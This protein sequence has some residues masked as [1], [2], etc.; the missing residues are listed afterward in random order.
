[1]LNCAVFYSDLMYQLSPTQEDS[2]TSCFVNI[3]L[4][5]KDIFRILK[6]LV[7]S[8]DA[9]NQLNVQEAYTFSAIS[10]IIYHHLFW[11]FLV[12]TFPFLNSSMILFFFNFAI[13]FNVYFSL[14]PKNFHQ[15]NSSQLVSL[16]IKYDWHF[17]ITVK[18]CR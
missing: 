16:L 4:L 12:L 10:L 8:K 6:Y 7:K 1:M 17:Q 18:F 14:L 9:L 15:I 13:I 2:M 3:M 11:V 5:Q